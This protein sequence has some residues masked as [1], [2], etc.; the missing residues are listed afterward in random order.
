MAGLIWCF[1]TSGSNLESGLSVL[2]EILRRQPGI[3]VIVITAFAMFE[4]AVEAMKMGAVDYLPKP[5]TPEQVRAAAK[6][7]VTAKVLKRQITELRARLDETEGEST[8]DT[9]NPAYAAFL[10]IA[11]RAAASDAVVMLRGESGSGKTVF[12]R[13]IRKQSRALVEVVR[14]SRSIAPCFPATS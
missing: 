4:S 12:A 8:F 2:P 10:Q 13:W 7:V 3:G 1:S 9:K 5:F 14:L 6:R 11:G